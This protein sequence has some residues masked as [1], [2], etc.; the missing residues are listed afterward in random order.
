MNRALAPNPTKTQTS[1]RAAAIAVAVAGAAIAAQSAHAGVLFTSTWDG[2]AANPEW[3]AG[4]NWSGGFG[5]PGAHHMAIFN[6]VSNQYVVLQQNGANPGDNI[7]IEVDTMRFDEG[8]YEM[9]NPQPHDHEIHRLHVVNG[10][11]EF[12]GDDMRVFF[13]Q[14]DDENF[15]VDFE[16]GSKMTFSNK[17]SLTTSSRASALAIISGDGT[18]VLD[19]ET[20][21]NNLLIQQGATVDVDNA[22]VQDAWGN[23]QIT[24]DDGKIQLN[25]D[26]DFQQI[27]ATTTL[28]AGGGT[29][30][31]TPGVEASWGGRIT[32]SGQLTKSGQGKLT[33]ERAVGTAT[34]YTGGTLLKAGELELI[35]SSAAGSGDITINSGANNAQLT[36]LNDGSPTSYANN[37]VLNDALRI[38]GDA[39]LTGDISGSGDLEKVGADTLTLTGVNTSTGSTIITEGGIRVLTADALAGTVQN[40]SE[41]EFDIAGASTLSQTISGSG[42]LVKSGNGVL[43]IT[44]PQSFSTGIQIDR[45][46]LALTHNDALGTAAVGVRVEAGAHSSATLSLADG[47]DISSI[48]LIDAVTDFEVASGSAQFSGQITGAA[49]VNKTG[50]GSLVLSSVNAFDGLTIT[51]G[52]VVLTDNLAA[53]V[54][55]DITVAS[56]ATN[57]ALTLSDGASIA[58][59]LALND[60]VEVTVES[61]QAQFAT[62]QLVSG[63]GVLTKT[64]DG[65]LFLRNNN[66]HG[67]TTVLGGALLIESNDSFGANGVAISMGSGGAIQTNN[68]LTSGRDVALLSGGG[69]IDV[70]TVNAATLN[71][72]ISGE[73]SLTKR[74]VG[75]L[76]LNGANTHTGGL[77]LEQGRLILDGASSAGDGAVTVGSG[78][79][80]AAIEFRAISASNRDFDND[81][82]INSRTE[83]NVPFGLGTPTFSGHISGAAP[84]DFTG[85]GFFFITG[86]A[87][88]GDL[89]FQDVMQ[90]SMDGADY[91]IAALRVG[92]SVGTDATVLIV[93]GSSIDAS[94]SIQVGHEGEGTLEIDASEANATAN[95]VVGRHTTGDGIARV[96]N[97]S[98]VNSNEIFVGRDGKG[99]LVVNGGSTMTALGDLEIGRNGAGSDGSVT[100]N[101]AGTLLDVQDAIVGVQGV[102]VLRVVNGEM[103]VRDDIIIGQQAGSDGTLRLDGGVTTANDVVLGAGAATVN[104]NNSATLALRSASEF[105]GAKIAALM[106]GPLQAGR[107]LVSGSATTISADLDVSGRMFVDDALDASDPTNGWLVVGNNNAGDLTISGGT[108][109]AD[110]I[111]VIAR[112]SGSAGLLTIDGGALE[113]ADLRFGAGDAALRIQSGAVTLTDDIITN[114]SGTATLTITDNASLTV[115]DEFTL[116][117]NS[118]LAF[119]FSAASDAGAT[120][121]LDV[122]G[123]FALNG[124]LIL[125]FTSGLIPEEADSFNLF[126]AAST[127]GS[128]AELILPELTFGL[129]YD[130]S[131]LDTDGVIS[132][133][134]GKVSDDPRVS[135]LANP[136]GTLNSPLVPTPGTFTLSAVALA[137]TTRRNRRD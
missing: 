11:H 62:A 91:N 31:T 114:T 41:L 129:V 4:N 65:T 122:G 77:I 94:T 21:I 132:V 51:E 116:R 71:G 93:N 30:Q 70:S 105:D 69:V 35:G 47:L 8:A 133:I 87:D 34:D 137:L 85:D 49:G 19:H 40:N 110:E 134:T 73:G 61:G 43:T 125:D 76:R 68:A 96:K 27:F 60:N 32:G 84:V 107:T 135:Y 3:G 97:G 18:L 37:L 108:T 88:M 23:S 119:E 48:A 123:D 9:F 117:N 120:G 89:F 57:A 58:T 95:F 126:D 83:F 98:V 52:R 42:S 115:A 111:V 64:G 99:A 121:L 63:S 17:I 1:M 86:T 7:P 39:T 26:G 112:N 55:S 53:G 103:N 82:V 101:N 80:D 15:Y 67:G 104:F 6:N 36:L 38:A 45:G 124:A 22:D 130:T 78:A 33:L 28:N 66:T 81:F 72:D 128:F 75:D 56:G 54:A 59:G 2:S 90:A 20:G 46:T 74:G 127:S 102:G 13:T 131:S 24:L 10:N 29:I 14:F 12:R 79:A 92:E 109:T 100:V 5:V 136:M 118:M 16:N 106:G 25:V 113:S 44:G 50:A